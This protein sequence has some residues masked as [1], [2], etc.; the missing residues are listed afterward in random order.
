V[1]GPGEYGE[2]LARAFLVREGYRIIQANYRFHHG[3]IDIVAEEGDVLVFCEVKTRTNDRYGAP[4]LALTAPKQHQIRKIALAYLT[5]H[6][7]H[8]RVCRFDVVAIRLGPR[9]PDITLIRD[10]FR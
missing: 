2:R 4:E 3:E 6:Q 9:G 5:V 7:C 10:A 1:K 8:D